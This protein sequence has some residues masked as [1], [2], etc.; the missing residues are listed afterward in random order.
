MRK[1]G[2]SFGRT[3]MLEHLE[4]RTLMSLGLT[5]PS[6]HPRLWWDAER[7]ARA[8]AWYASNPF[9]P[10]ADD[11]WGNA[12][13]YRITGDA[14]NARAAI[15]RMM[16]FR[17]PDNDLNGTKSDTYRWEDW[18]PVVYDWCY[19][20]MTPAERAEFTDRY[21][22]YAQ[23][24]MGKL[25]GGPG[26]PGNNYFWGYLRNEFNWAVASWGENP[27]AETFLNDA[28]VTRWQDSFVPY[29]ASDARGGT[30]PEG[31]QYG[32]YLLQYP[33]VPFT[34]AGLMGRDLFGET[35]FYREA[36]YNLVYAT[37]NGRWPTRRGRRRSTSCSPTATTSTPRATRGPPTTTTATSSPPWPP[38]PRAATRPWRAT[39][40]TGSPP[41]GPARP[42][43]ATWRR[44][45]TAAAPP[46]GASRRCPPTT[47]PRGCR[48]STPA[49]RGRRGPPTWC[50]RWASRPRWATA[51]SR[52]AASS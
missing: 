6:E 10:P 51:T 39:P 26:G 50:C 33:V 29:A 16:A 47:T 31:S 32:R 28:L 48:T 27:M 20:Q 1:G 17:V 21:N 43:A 49:R 40:D 23:T 8:E 46:P 38:G 12:L 25:W 42:S 45:T 18:V 30:P 36:L 37:S 4:T 22:Y 5:I 11:A 52:P 44:P 24:M 34:S 9:S 13:R 41:P 35:N 19:D 7:E 14:A 2:K 3:M 15:S